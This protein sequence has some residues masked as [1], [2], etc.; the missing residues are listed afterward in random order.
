M[1][2]GIQTCRVTVTWSMMILVR[3]WTI[4]WTD[5]LSCCEDF[6]DVNVIC[7]SCLVSVSIRLHLTKTNLTKH[8]RL[9]NYWQLWMYPHQVE[10]KLATPEDRFRERDWINGLLYT[11]C[12]QI[13]PHWSETGTGTRSIVSCTCPGPRSGPAQCEQAIMAHSHCTGTEMGQG[14]GMGLA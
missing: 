11:K 6:N 8:R 10:T 14:L 2:T 12:I 1:A 7:S 5:L 9:I 13:S 3:L 4:N